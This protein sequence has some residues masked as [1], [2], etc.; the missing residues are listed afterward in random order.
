MSGSIS[1]LEICIRSVEPRAVDAALVFV[2]GHDTNDL[3]NYC[4]PRELFN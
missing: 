4:G 2:K 3:A 1:V